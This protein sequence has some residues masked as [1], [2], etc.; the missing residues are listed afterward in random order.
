MVVSENVWLFLLSM[1]SMVGGWIMKMLFNKVQSIEGT[2]NHI[3]R[4][5]PE[6][7]V[8][9]EDFKDSLKSIDNKLDKVLD[10]LDTKQDKRAKK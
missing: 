5:L 10:K 8:T 2:V 3:E 6:K 1:T 7:Y 4:T 9:K